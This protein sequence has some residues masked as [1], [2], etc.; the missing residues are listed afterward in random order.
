MKSSPTRMK[1][2]DIRNIYINVSFLPAPPLDVLSFAKLLTEIVRETG[3]L[4][5]SHDPETRVRAIG[6][7][8]PHSRHSRAI[9]SL[10][11]RR[12]I[13]RGHLRFIGDGVRP[14]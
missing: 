5:T 10:R 14:D 12:A 3:Q 6:A 11:I 13:R 8:P 2:I 1:S 9:E 4:V 7:D